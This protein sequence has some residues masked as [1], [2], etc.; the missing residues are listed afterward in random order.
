M[1]GS[2]GPYYKSKLQLKSNLSKILPANCKFICVHIFL[3]VLIVRLED[4]KF[5]FYQFKLE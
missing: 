2:L 3:F 5:E 1:Y 4:L